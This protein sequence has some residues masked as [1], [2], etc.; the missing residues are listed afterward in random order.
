MLC[1]TL[2][3]PA[4]R[5]CDGMLGG[6]VRLQYSMALRRGQDMWRTVQDSGRS[7]EEPVG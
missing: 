6:A 1:T 7:G 4:G 3:G 2:C 5:W